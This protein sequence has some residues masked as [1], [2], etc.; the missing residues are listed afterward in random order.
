MV[1]NCGLTRSTV[2][3]PFGTPPGLISTLQGAGFTVLESAGLPGPGNANE[4][5]V[6]KLSG[7]YSTAE[8]AELHDWVKGGGAAMVMAVGIGD[9]EE[10]TETNP[11]IAPFGLAYSCALPVTWGPVT[12]FV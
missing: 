10:C 3:L 8:G 4:I 9:S 5:V 12:K 1:G 6:V 7:A 2:R 11:V